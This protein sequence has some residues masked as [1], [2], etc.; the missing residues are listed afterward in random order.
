[1]TSK[2]PDTP[3]RV[4]A[5]IA[6]STF[7][8]FFPFARA[9]S[10]ISGSISTP[11]PASKKPANSRNDRLHP[12]RCRAQ[13]TSQ[14]SQNYL[15]VIQWD[16]RTGVIHARKV[17]TGTLLHSAKHLVEF[18]LGIALLHSSIGSTPPRRRRRPTPW[19]Q[20]AS[21]GD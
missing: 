3:S 2:A 7:A 5:E 4:S 17:P 14:I 15:M 20:V 13:L 6:N 19:A 11:R 16:R 21:A 1:M 9:R 10:T 18:R 8:V 12:F